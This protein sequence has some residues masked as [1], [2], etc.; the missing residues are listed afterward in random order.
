MRM[1]RKKNLEE[2]IQASSDYLTIMHNDSLNY[3]DAVS[4]DH[5]LNF[6]ELF[7]NDKPV[8][9]EVGSGKGQFGC[10]FAQRNPD[11]KYSLC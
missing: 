10:T 7:G 2:R 9:L 4:E 3:N 1:K 5:K 11:K 6:Q 8:Y